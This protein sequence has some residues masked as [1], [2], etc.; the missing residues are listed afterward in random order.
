MEL[1]HGKRFER[2]WHFSATHVFSASCFSVLDDQCPVV[3][4]TCRLDLY[5]RTVCRRCTAA[6]HDVLSIIKWLPSTDQ[7]EPQLATRLFSLKLLGGMAVAGAGGIAMAL[8]FGGAAASSGAIL[9]EFYRFSSSVAHAVGN[10]AGSAL[11]RTSSPTEKT[12]FRNAS[13]GSIIGR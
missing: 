5:R 13:H 11:A 4:C 8:F 1:G 2:S 10:L 12:N 9:A 3:C 6:N 7:Q